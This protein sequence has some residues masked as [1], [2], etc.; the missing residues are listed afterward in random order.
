M[1]DSKKLTSGATLIQELW[2]IFNYSCNINMTVW[3]FTKKTT[4]QSSKRQAHN[5]VK[6]SF[7]KKKIKASGLIH[8]HF[9]QSMKPGVPS[10]GYL[11]ESQAANGS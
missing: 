11:P 6:I 2:V 9:L 7:R 8:K 5:K 10:T 1:T 4:L 3:E